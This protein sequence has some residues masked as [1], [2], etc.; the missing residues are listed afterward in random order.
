MIASK[1]ND[2][3]Y[4]QVFYDGQVAGSLVSARVILGLL[5]HYFPFETVVDVGCG[6]GT[7][8]AASLEGGASFAA[9]LDGPWNTQDQMV[10]PKVRFQSVDLESKNWADQLSCRRFDLV[11][12]MEVAE[13]L[14][15]TIARTFVGELCRL[16]DVVL[17]SAAF[18]GQ[19]GQNH[20]NEKRHSEWGEIF[21]E[22]GYAVFDLFRPFLWADDSVETCYRQNAFLYVKKGSDAMQGYFE[23]RH[24]PMPALAFMDCIH[25]EIW[26]SRLR[27]KTF[28]ERLARLGPD[29]AK[30]LKKR[31]KQLFRPRHPA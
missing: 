11:I 5:K 9:G 16:A 14:S 20:I 30:S 21:M 15:P 19:R 13:H 12:C 4:D 17:F 2:E 27:R 10:N 29:A 3:H 18:V 7:W 8:A 1:R 6:H 22:Q 31:A 26:L 28:R 25:P 23:N 24:E